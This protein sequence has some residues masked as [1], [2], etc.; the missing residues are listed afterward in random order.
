M[1]GDGVDIR[2]ARACL[3]HFDWAEVEVVA[4]LIAGSM[5]N[6]FF[7]SLSEREGPSSAGQEAAAKKPCDPHGC[8]SVAPSS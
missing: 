6:H 8:V 7:S 1:E 3:Q 5:S 2:G 4:R